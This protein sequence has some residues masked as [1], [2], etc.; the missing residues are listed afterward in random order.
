MDT[1]KLKVGR[2]IFNIDENDIIM[3]N[4]ACYQLITKEIGHGWNK[5]PPR[6]SKKMFKDLKTVGFIFTNDKLDKYAKERYS[7]K[8]TLYKFNIEAMKKNWGA[9]ESN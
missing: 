7:V 3:D 5:Y 6:V 4:G 8:V 2:G 9:Y 1:I